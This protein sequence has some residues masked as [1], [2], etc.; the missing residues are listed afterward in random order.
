M[1]EKVGVQ[2]SWASMDNFLSNGLGLALLDGDEIASA[3]LSVFASRERLE[4]DVHTDEKYQRRGFARLTAS[5]F[6]EAC[7]KRGQQPNWECF[8]END[9]STKLAGRLGFSA[10]PDYP[11]YFWEE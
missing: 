3:C 6:I 4:I 7:L 2:A 5:A 9:A 8:W 11:V 10:E 1:A